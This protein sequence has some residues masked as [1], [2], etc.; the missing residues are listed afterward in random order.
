MD[1]ERLRGLRRGIDS[2]MHV[3]CVKLVFRKKEDRG[4]P[5]LRLNKG[6]LEG[7]LNRAFLKNVVA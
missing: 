3:R 6:L 1:L 5:L 2:Q 4:V 7:C